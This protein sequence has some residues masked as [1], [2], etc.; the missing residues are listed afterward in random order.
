VTKRRPTAS[1]RRRL[2]VS[3]LVPGLILAVLLGVGGAVL[4]ND[5][6]AATH[7][8]LLDGALL[9]ISERV[10][11]EEGE[12]TVDIPLAAFG[13]LESQAQDSIYYSIVYDG[14]IVTGYSDLPLDGQ[15]RLA[16]GKTV[17]RDA[18]YKGQSVRLAAQS[19]WLYGKSKPVLVAIAETTS[20]RRAL[21]H[22][23]LLALALLETA[24][25]TVLGVL[26]WFA[27]DRGLRPLTDLSDAIDARGVH[28]ALSFDPL[29]LQ[30]VPTEALA[31]AIALNALLRRL[32]DSV[33]ANQR[34]TADASHQMRTP[35]AIMQTHLTLARRHIAAPDI[36]DTALTELDNAV[37]RLD[38]MAS[39]LIA[40]ARADESTKS[41]AE[42]VCDLGLVV[43]ELVADRFPHALAAGIEIQ[44][45]RP[46][47]PILIR[48]PELLVRELAANLL[49]NA[50]RY[51]HKGGSV[52]VRIGIDQ[53]VTRLEIEDSGP[54]IPAA[55][56]ARVFDR[57][58]RIPR[59]DGPQ[60]SG[61]GLAIVRAICDRIGASIT[62]GDRLE[63][64]G[65][66]VTVEFGA[67]T[68]DVKHLV[69]T[70][71]ATG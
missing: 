8:R 12:V 26:A 42:P 68:A 1:L 41:S 27:V 61:L 62:L 7:D 54:G 14:H 50:I 58:Y 44:V 39:Q 70:R 45:E 53:P 34:F 15:L 28:N 67:G 24:L 25:L 31:P 33:G 55:E 69:A 56:R 36:V 48:S 52:D 49:D 43:P 11:V 35:L 3:L 5:V 16:P 51:N 30:S 19:R 9:A 63:G 37:R 65:L 57:F 40:L 47:G 60:G 4:I 18:I 20:A 6:V 32:H 59:T 46:D 21:E 66:L 17:Y 22:R 13:M 2:L 29:D 64:A 71:S 10:G 38:R 23:M